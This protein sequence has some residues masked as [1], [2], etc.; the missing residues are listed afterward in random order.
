MVTND[1]NFMLRGCIS[2]SIIQV[3]IVLVEALYIY[4]IQT[5]QLL[6]IVSKHTIFFE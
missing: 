4:K 1:E 6:V 2:P 5:H 3:Q